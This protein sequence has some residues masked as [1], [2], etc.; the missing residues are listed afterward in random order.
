MSTWNAKAAKA[1][2]EYILPLRRLRPLRSI[3]DVRSLGRVGPVNRSTAVH[4]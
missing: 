1:A 2:K 3:V 4:P